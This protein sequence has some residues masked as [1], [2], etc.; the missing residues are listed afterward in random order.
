MSV[1]TITV[2]QRDPSNSVNNVVIDFFDMATGQIV[3][4]TS[5]IVYYGDHAPIIT[6]YMPTN[7]N[8]DYGEIHAEWTDENF[9]LWKNDQFIQE[10]KDLGDFE[11]FN[12]ARQQGIVV[13]RYLPWNE[14]DKDPSSLDISLYTPPTDFTLE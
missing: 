2:L 14:I 3:E 7:G 8:N 12:Y 10:L 4:T 5:Q 13:T 1:K 6:Y 11:F 9:E